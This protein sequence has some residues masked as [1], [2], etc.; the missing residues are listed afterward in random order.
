MKK[1]QLLIIILAFAVLL[2]AY[3]N[4]KP[5]A[6]KLVETHGFAGSRFSVDPQ[7]RSQDIPDSILVFLVQFEDVKFDT[8]ADFPDF[9]PHDKAYFH[10]LMFHLSTYWA[11][12]SYN[13]YRIVDE[14]DSL[15]TIYDQIITLPNTMTYYGEDSD[16]G[17]I[18][19]RKVE[20]VTDLLAQVD[21]LID[22][23]DYDTYMMFHA[24]AGQEAHGD[25]EPQ[26]LY[27]TFL[28]RKSFQAALDPENDDI[29][30]SPYRRRY[31]F[32]RDH[33]FP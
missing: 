26:L 12:A 14:N 8:V 24:G 28:S 2:P 21:P 19:E 32:Y 4:I 13:N 22:F 6:L 31:L 27:S 1:F 23:N 15:Y 29:S 3:N 16:G 5:D 17:D 7:N 10:R 33:D 18:I 20:L 25:A 30:R 9:I 11:D